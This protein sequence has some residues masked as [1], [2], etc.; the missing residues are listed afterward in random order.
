MP[1]VA[2]DGGAEFDVYAEFLERRRQA[3]TYVCTSKIFRD[4]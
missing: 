2:S 4:K 1:G 3:H